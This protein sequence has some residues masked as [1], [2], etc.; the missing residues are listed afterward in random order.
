MGKVEETATKGWVVHGEKKWH[1][2]GTKVLGKEFG[3]ERETVCPG[4]VL[5]LEEGCID[6]KC[7]TAATSGS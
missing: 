3:P 6:Q 1:E 4:S 5:V 7:K 2:I